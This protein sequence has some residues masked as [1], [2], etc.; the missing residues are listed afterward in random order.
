MTPQTR[1]KIKNFKNDIAGL[2]G[3]ITGL[4][5]KLMSSDSKR[6]TYADYLEQIANIFKTPTGRRGPYYP[7]TEET[8]TPGFQDLPA[9]VQDCVSENELLSKRIEDLEK[10][11]AHLLRVLA[12]DPQLTIEAN[13]RCKTVIEH[14]TDGVFRPTLYNID[15]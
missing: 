1:K 4:E 5:A 9:W 10:Q 11:L 7:H 14:H 8:K 3:R 12:K 13:E 6:D 2:L 15:P